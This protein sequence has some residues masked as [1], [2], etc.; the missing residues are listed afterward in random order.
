MARIFSLHVCGIVDDLFRIGLDAE[1]ENERLPHLRGRQ[2]LNASSFLGEDHP[3]DIAM[4]NYSAGSGHDTRSNTSNVDVSITGT[5]ACAAGEDDGDFCL[6]V[7][8]SLVSIGG[9]RVTSMR[10]GDMIYIHMVQYSQCLRWVT[11]W[12]TPPYTSN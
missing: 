8:I 9:G 3:G 10:P 6:S 12:L 5:K 11:T 1:H 7:H 4:A 2:S